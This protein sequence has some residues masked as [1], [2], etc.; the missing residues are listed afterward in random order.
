MVKLRRGNR[1]KMNE[2]RGRCEISL[3]LY[4]EKITCGNAD[5]TQFM[6]WQA[7]FRHEFGKEP[8]ETSPTIERYVNK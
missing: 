6:H 1:E 8:K 4:Q 5:Y 7:T 3:P 2:F